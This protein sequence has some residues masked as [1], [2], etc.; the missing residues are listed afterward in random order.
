MKVKKDDTI[1]FIFLNDTATTEIY[2]LSLHDALPIS[3]EDGEHLRDLVQP[4]L[5]QER[6][7]PGH[8]RVLVR[9]PD[10]A[11]ALLRVGAHGAKLADA[12]DPSP[13]AHPLLSVEDRAL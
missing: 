6:A 1:F 13:P 5:A 3:R 7:D 2:T 4:G 11:R 12:E 10:G 8:P 9:G